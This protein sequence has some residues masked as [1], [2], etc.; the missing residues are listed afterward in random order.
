MA[1][2]HLSKPAHWTRGKLAARI[3]HTLLDP[4][5]TH[6]DILMACEI[7][8]RHGCATACLNSS[9]VAAAAEVL[10][11][12][13]TGIAA[14]VGFPFGACHMGAKATETRL[15]VLDG[16]TE[17]DMVLDIGRLKDGDLEA[18]AADIRSVIEAATAPR[19]G[20]PGVRAPDR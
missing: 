4:A 12:S 10:A 14:V 2:V 5:A 20:H 15:A 17:I 16:A 8:R 7:A 18:V 3:D 1:V 11:G 13:A 19:Q 9:R 6:H